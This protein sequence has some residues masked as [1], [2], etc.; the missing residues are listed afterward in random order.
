MQGKLLVMVEQANTLGL[1]SQ[2]Q[3]L[4]VA[5]GSPLIPAERFIPMGSS[6]QAMEI[7]PSDASTTPLSRAG[8]NFARRISRG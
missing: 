5:H 7:T 1:L 8:R 3:H 6:R 4:L 2:W